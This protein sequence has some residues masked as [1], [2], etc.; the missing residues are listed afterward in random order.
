MLYYWYIK[1]ALKTTEG[2][3]Q[4]DNINVLNIV[5]EMFKSNIF[6]FLLVHVV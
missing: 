3:I 5:F 2:A 6:Y 1:Q 4:T